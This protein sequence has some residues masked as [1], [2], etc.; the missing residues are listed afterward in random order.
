[1]HK[2]WLLL[3]NEYFCYF[4]I[5]CVCLRC[6][7]PVRPL[8]GHTDVVLCRPLKP[9][10]HT[11]S[12]KGKFRVLLLPLDLKMVCSKHVRS[13]VM[14]TGHCVHA[15]Y[16]GLSGVCHIC[17]TLTLSETTLALW[18]HTLLAPPPHTICVLVF[19]QLTLSLPLCI[20]QDTE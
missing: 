7:I 6:S 1:M 20:L 4:I 16:W 8:E 15:C 14:F 3:N 18:A 9:I 12:F 2:K 5:F 10:K 17:I 19:P 11:N 13:S